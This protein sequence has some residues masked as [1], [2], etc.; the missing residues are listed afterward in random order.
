MPHA[1]T[2]VMP[3]PL[4]ISVVIPA[5]NAAAYLAEALDSVARQRRPAAETIVVD[6]GSSD[7]SA[8]LARRFGVRVI[9]QPNR[10]VA[11]A[12][13]AGIVAATQPWIAFLDADDR[14]HPERLAAQWQALEGCSAVGIVAADYRIFRGPATLEPSG[15]ALAAGYR[16][17]R[18]R[19][20]AA[21]AVLLERPAIVE[22][23]VTGYFLQPSTLLVAR[24]LFVDMNLWFT[25]REDLPATAEFHVGEDFELMLRLLRHS[26]VVLVERALVD[27]R[28]SATSLS[29]DAVRM[30]S[31]DI[32]L[33]EYVC[34]APERYAAGAAE[35][36]LR[37]RPFKLRDTGRRYLAAGDIRRAHAMFTR[38]AAE[39]DRLARP[40]AVLTRPYTSRFG[41]TAFG[42]LWH[43]WRRYVR[44]WV[45]RARG[46]A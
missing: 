2:S 28:L 41:V 9:T 6:D 42:A 17:L 13:N 32:V 38:A 35:A 24:R 12:R 33:G 31:G 46:A 21:G 23:L 20:L 15:L 34:A 45:H 43:I 16:G 19:P 37:I 18:R 3:D 14:W 10:G 22:A 36:F 7:D 11:Q 1:K 30:R 27:Y 39:R 44:P 5:Y 4:P 8:S 26:D 40:F 25:S 29:A